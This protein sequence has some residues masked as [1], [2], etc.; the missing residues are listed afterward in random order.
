MNTANAATARFTRTSMRRPAI[1]AHRRRLVALLDDGTIG[2]AALQRIQD[3]LDW[4]E[5]DWEQL[6]RTE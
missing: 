5:L 1:A 2:D 6:F 3:E 4:A